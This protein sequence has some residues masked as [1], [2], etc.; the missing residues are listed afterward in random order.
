M[1]RNSSAK[2][3]CLSY[4]LVTG[5][6]GLG[7]LPALVKRFEETFTLSHQQ[8]GLLMGTGMVAMAVGTFGGGVLFD[9]FG[10]RMAIGSAMALSA[11]FAF[12]LGLTETVSLFVSAMLLFFA[13]T[14]MGNVATPLIARLYAPYQDSGL[15]LAHGI[16]G[17]GRLCAPLLVVVCLW[18]GGGWQACFA[19]TG[20][21]L[22]VLFVLFL[23]RFEETAAGQ[24]HP[25]PDDASA[26]PD[27]PPT[28]RA[29]VLLGIIGF[30][31]AAGAEAG[32]ISWMPTFLEAEAA[33]GKATALYALT[34]LMAA[35]T[36][37]RILL[38]LHKRLNPRTLIPMSVPFYLLAFF[39]MTHTRET[40]LLY[41]ACAVLGLCVG[42]CWPSLASAVYRRS[43]DGHGKVTGFIILAT[44][45]GACAFLTV[46]GWIGSTYGLGRALL[47]A[48]ICVIVFAAIYIVLLRSDR[49]S[50]RTP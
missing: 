39:V 10:S 33:F 2:R 3:L 1:S 24:V 20:A 30:V 28:R 49:P 8:M 44:T 40:W 25:G 47:L 21:L 17:V 6:T 16:H 15:N 32:L 38:A 11:L 5:V 7:L 42:P 14:G 4:F 23:T 50:A 46:I 37:I 41:P 35:Y 19:V 29:A 27:A 36:L 18:A 13:T 31:F 48:P 12:V 43:P 34:F 26:K 9:R 22:A 45:T